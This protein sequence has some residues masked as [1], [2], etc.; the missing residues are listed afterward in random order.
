M[1]PLNHTIKYYRFFLDCS[2]YSSYL[3]YIPRFKT[4]A[5]LRQQLNKEVNLLPTLGANTRLNVKIGLEKISI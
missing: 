4:M 1:M 5:T 3:V 2:K